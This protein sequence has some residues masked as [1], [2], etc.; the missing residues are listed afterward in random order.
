VDG[1]LVDRRLRGDHALVEG[2]PERQPADLA[3][4]EHVEGP[5]ASLGTGGHQELTRPR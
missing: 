3:L 2:L 1:V 5:F 4:E